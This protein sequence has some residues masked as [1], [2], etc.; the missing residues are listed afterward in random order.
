MRHGKQQR[1]G[2]RVAHIIF[3][4]C[5][6]T[7][8]TYMAMA[9]L[10][11][12]SLTSSSTVSRQQV[13]VVAKPQ[14]VDVRS[15]TDL[16]QTKPPRIAWSIPVGGKTE[17]LA[18]LERVLTKLLSSGV[19]PDDIYV[20][21][22]NE[23]RK[24]LLGTTSASRRLSD[25]SAKYGVHVLQSGVVRDRREKANE[26]GLFL[27][28]HYHFMFDALLYD[29]TSDPIGNFGAKST[30][31]LVATPYDFAVMIEDDLELMDDAVAYF[32]H[33]ST[34]MLLD[35][36][37]FCVCAHA[38]NAFHGFSSEPVQS[39]DNFV[40]PHGQASEKFLIRR[41]NH[42]MAPGFMVSR[43]VYNTVIRPTWL[44]KNGD[45]L[46]RDVMK[47]PNGNWDTYLDAR[48]R[49]LECIFP[50]VPRIAHRG[51]TG[52]TVRPDRQD[53][54]FSS[55][56]LSTLSAKTDYRQAALDVVLTAYESKIQTFMDNAIHIDC[57]EDLMPLRNKQVMLHV[58]G[59]Q[60]DGDHGW[61]AALNFFGLIG[62]G[63]HFPRV[64]GIHRGTV[65]VEY[66]GNTVL[67]VADYSPFAS[68]M[69]V[70][71]KGCRGIGSSE[72][73]RQPGETFVAGNVGES[74]TAACKRNG[75]TCQDKMVG[76]LIDCGDR[77]IC[78]ATKKEWSGVLDCQMDSFRNLLT[79]DLK[80]A[81]PGISSSGQ[82]IKTIGRHLSCLGKNDNIKRACICS[83]MH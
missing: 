47:M 81:A 51:A 58:K 46:Q 73:A 33:M 13:D 21:E 43:P 40:F 60:N 70:Q 8:L 36:T 1:K 34:A 11:I 53:A 32:T 26:F 9:F 17:R 30:Q 50:S 75:A 3:G 18:L 64:R 28:R 37:I 67:L 71:G 57:S 79:G 42:F 74:C 54:V 83:S 82:C 78:G 27:A 23:S 66:L 5:I 44:H 41:G 45:V 7:L 6:G 19:A 48:I 52:Y 62:I 68:R 59:T 22:D 72:S 49:Q 39:S 25:F 31:E 15:L 12:G 76:L 29:G 63:G 10:H 4:C 38:D 20:M 35:P 55:L 69:K 77:G 14:D 24:G 2:P 61:A 80:R 16:S 56:R 65:I